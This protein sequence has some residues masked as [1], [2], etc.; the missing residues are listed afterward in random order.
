MK[1]YLE[2]K[3][4]VITGAGSGVG[5]AA[6]LLFTEH[7]AKV[8]AADINLA[9]AEESLELAGLAPD[10]GRA[11]E[12]NVVDPASVEA[13]VQAAVAAFG[14]LDVMYNNAGITIMPDPE[15]GL[16]T[17]VDAPHDEMKRVEDVNINGVV[18]GCQ[19]AIR[20]FDRQGNGGV[21]INTASITGI[22][23]F[24]ATLYGATKGAVVALTR[25]LAIEVADKNI[26]V[27]S[28]CP[29]AMLTHYSGFD[30]D[31]PNA[32]QIKAGM[33]RLHPL[34]RSI[35]PADTAAAAMFLASDLASNITGVNLPVDGGLTAGKNVRAA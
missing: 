17:L 16:R 30:P 15:K 22:F 5:R 1:G 29:G 14:R 28:V 24:G 18:Y 3:V 25:L 26:R 35:D 13:A 20:Q 4:V 9:T 27:N 10:R 12:C 8:I 2:D 31:G 19:S 34:G 32:D 6:T 7:G 21:I 23:G 33:G 11:V